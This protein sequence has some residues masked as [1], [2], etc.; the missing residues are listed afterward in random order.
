MKKI[1]TLIAVFALAVAA[2]AQNATFDVTGEGTDWIVISATND[3][4]LGAWGFKLDLPEGTDLA[5]DDDEEDYVYERNT[6]RIAKK[7]TI[8]IK[9]TATGY[10]FNI[11]G[12][13]MKL[14]EGEML[15]LKLKNPITGDAKFYAINF[16][17]IGEDGKGTTSVYHKGNK[18]YEKILS[19]KA[20]AINSIKA[21]E[22]KSGA[23]YNLNG[24][25]VSKATKG[26]YV[27]DG[28]KYAVK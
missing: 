25:R 8:D 13:E 19:L 5:Y 20:D 18:D 10:S 2:K 23:I 28:K 27:I 3:F 6:A 14:S 26:I 15:R 4:H 7:A 9:K 11:Y 22:T 1:F 17:D 21:E 12:V 24:Q 16:T